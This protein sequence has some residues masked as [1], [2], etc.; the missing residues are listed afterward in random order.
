MRTTKPQI[1]LGI[2]CLDGIIYKFAI[3][4]IP[5]LWLASVAE[6]LRDCTTP[7]TGTDMTLL[8]LSYLCNL[9]H[10]KEGL[11]G[12]GGGVPKIANHLNF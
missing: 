4:E 11:D 7:K 5:R 12:G 6:Q 10:M 3:S 1:S 9:Y 2:H 8:K